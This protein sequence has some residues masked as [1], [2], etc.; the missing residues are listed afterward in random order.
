MRET[1]ESMLKDFKKK[2]PEAELHSTEFSKFV[3]DRYVNLLDKYDTMFI[4]MK[5][6][7]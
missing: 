1:V 7:L 3:Y 4:L 6:G 2:F 5:E